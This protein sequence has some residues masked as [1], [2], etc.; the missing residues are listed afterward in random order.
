MD[1]L[2]EK[3][4][5]AVESKE[6]P[7]LVIAGPGSGKT[8]VIEY[9]VLSLVKNGVPPEKILLLTFTKRAA[10][11]MLERAAIHDKRCVSVEGG[12]FHSFAYKLLR[13]YGEKI[14][15]RK[16]LS[17][18]D[19][20]DAEEVVGKVLGGID[21]GNKKESFPKK[22]TLRKIFSLSANKN[23]E[24]K[25]A[26]DRYF[27]H[28]SDF[29]PDME[30]I[31]EKY[32][33]YKKENGYLDFDDLLLY[34]RDL[35]SLKEIGERISS[36]YEFVMVDEFQDT[37]PLQG[38]ITRL[39][40][41]EKK[42]LLV[43]GD[44]AQSIYGF[45]GASHKNIMEFPEMFPGTKIIKLEENYRSTQ[46]ILNLSNEL[47]SNMREKFQKDLFSGKGKTG[48][49]PKMLYFANANDEVEW[50]T[51]EI[52]KEARKGVS[53]REQAILFRSTYVSILLQAE[54]SKMRI[55]Y[56][57]FGG[58]RFYEMAHIKDFLSYAKVISN[59]KD[60]IS[61]ERIFMMLPGVGKKTA[62]ALWLSLKPARD[63]AEGLLIL[64]NRGMNAKNPESI[65]KLK[66]MLEEVRD[67]G[68][69]VYN[70]SGRIMDFYL[71]FFKEKFDD[72]PMR[73]QD[74][75]TLRELSENYDDLESFLAD[76][77]IDIPEGES[78]EN[79]DFLTLSTIHSAKGLEWKA[80]YVLG[81]TE[82]TLPSKRSMDFEEDIEEE[83][84][85]LYVAVTRA[86]DKLCLLFHL[87]GGRGMYLGQRLSRFL[88]P[89][90]VFSS[91]NHEDLSGYGIKDE[92]R[93][94]EEDEGIDIW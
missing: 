39:L 50:L 31:G 73:L 82:G 91:L 74:L 92:V 65:L 4:K 90:N 61:W 29:I 72:W 59:F 13:L 27:S 71:P 87:D 6:G 9:R 75:E 79:D 3:Q 11:Q 43:V 48:D 56:K 14:G 32:L 37:N 36:K 17:V 16:T 33:E 69:N 15:L 34:A 60:E 23:I 51:E 52:L 68:N 57:L 24:I 5:E 1:V 25:E 35:L 58:V 28:L 10:R 63:L 94:N 70:L 45:R 46:S 38:E 8:R 53:L 86:K 30:S 77:S 64:E 44:D 49:K 22:D 2:N 42:N 18:L 7:V 41:G 55:P 19:E 26:V 54:L 62:E 40:G 83:G 67:S 66:R 80:V 78:D 21:L 76:I 88:E 89:E 20:A 12:T 81:V 84:R 47:L 85:L 93:W